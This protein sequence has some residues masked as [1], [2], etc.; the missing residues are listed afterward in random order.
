MA[1]RSLAAELPNDNPELHDG[2]IWVCE[3]LCG[4]PV[5]ELP[6]PREAAAIEDEEEEIEIVEELTIPEGVPVETIPPPAVSEVVVSDA[7]A[8]DPVMAEV[9]SAGAPADDPFARFVE[10]LV[11]VAE[12]AGS[13]DA[14]A[15]LPVLLGETPDRLS[16]EMI[17]LVGG[18]AFLRAADAWRRVLRGDGDAFSEV[19][20]RTLDEWAAEVIAKLLAAPNRSEQLRRELR[21][22]GIAAFGLLDAA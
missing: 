22:R 7:P 16:E 21:G 6:S 13:S 12:S 15:I 18:D 1:W 17:A 5:A 14:A 9:T 10:T 3:S 19:G 8:S 2:A 20:T 11:S 4:P